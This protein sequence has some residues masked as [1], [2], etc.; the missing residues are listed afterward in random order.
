MSYRNLIAG[1]LGSLFTVSA[2]YAS[3]DMSCDPSPRLRESDYSCAGVPFLSPNNDTRV[4]AIL[5]MSSDKVAKFL[6]NPQSVPAE[7]RASSLAG[8]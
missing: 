8:R 7:E 3:A 1:L 6:S 5:L 4:N 2:A